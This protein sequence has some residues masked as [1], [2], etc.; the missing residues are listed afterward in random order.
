MIKTEFSPSLELLTRALRGMGDDIQKKGL[1]SALGRAVKPIKDD[2]KR[3]VEAQ[4]VDTGG[5]RDSIGQRSLSV[6]GKGRLGIA[7]STVA[8]IVGSTR[9]I[10]SVGSDG[11]KRKVSQQRK[12]LFIEGGVNRNGRIISAPFLQPALDAGQAQMEELFYS[13]LQKFIDRQLK[14]KAK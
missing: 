12:A 6:T 7:P 13:G 9:K 10:P 11:K 4:S 8:V 1:R 5:L 2:A 14:K 3:R